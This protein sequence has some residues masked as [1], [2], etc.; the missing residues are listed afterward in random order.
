MPA[1]PEPFMSEATRVTAGVLLVTIVAVESGGLFMLRVVGRL[2]PATPFQ[3]AFFRAG[4]AHAGVLVTLALASQPFVDA[5]GLGGLTGSV[6]RS[7][8]ALAAILMP[9]GFVLSAWAT[10]ATKPNR[11]IVLVY[12]GAAALAAGALSLGLGLL[13]G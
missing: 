2:K 4:H 6:A 9:A 10:G 13:L 3:A 1:M 8:I 7:G 11:L 12:L 5:A